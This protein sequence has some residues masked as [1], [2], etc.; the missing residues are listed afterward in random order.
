[1][2]STPVIK[3]VQE[4][5][6]YQILEDLG[7]APFG[8]AYLAADTRSD[9]TAILKVIPP[10]RPGSWQ[11]AVPWEILLAETE[12]LGRIYHRGLPAL[13]EIAEHEGSLLV[14][15]AAAEGRTLHELLAQGERPDRATLIDW[16]CQLLEILAEAH[17]EGILHRHIAED[18]VILVPEGHLV[19]AGFGLTQ[20]VFDPLL[21]LPPEQLAGELYTVQSDL[22]AVGSLLRRLTFAG[23]LRGNGGLGVRDPLFRVLARATFQDPAARFRSAAEMAEALREAARNDDVTASRPRLQPVPALPSASA[24]ARVEVFPRAARPGAEERGEAWRALLMLMATL[25]L[26]VFVLATGWFLFGHESSAPPAAA[27]GSPVGSHLPA[28]SSH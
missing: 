22:Y 25:L 8:T 13:L 7:P 23:S 10:S 9:R 4:I 18:E 2:L 15:F 20:L 6:P 26:M 21:T 11:E 19:L 16:G 17:G 14:A 12:A 28:A 24:E 1:M 5:G 27:S 3:G